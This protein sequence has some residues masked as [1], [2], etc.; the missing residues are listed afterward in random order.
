MFEMQ[1]V[2]D[3]RNLRCQR[4]VSNTRDSTLIDVTWDLFSSHE[5]ETHF[6]CIRF[7][8]VSPVN[9]SE[10]IL[11]LYTEQKKKKKKKKRSTQSSI[12]FR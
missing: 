1:H 4:H 12:Y 7:T 3:R 10:T 11:I 8:D 2:F 9:N 6:T 5:I